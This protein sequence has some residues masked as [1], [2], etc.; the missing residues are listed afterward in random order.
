M[1]SLQVPFQRAWVSKARLLVYVSL[2]CSKGAI[3]ATSLSQCSSQEIHCKPLIQSARTLSVFAQ[4]LDS[5][6]VEQHPFGSFLQSFQK[7][8]KSK[9]HRRH[10]Q[11]QL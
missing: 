11:T 2:Q 6:E 10:S 4:W 7:Y 5:G 1:F 9:R 8:K 3:C